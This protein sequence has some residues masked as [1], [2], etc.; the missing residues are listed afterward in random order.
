MT[1]RFKKLIYT[2][3]GGMALFPIATLAYD[4]SFD[5]TAGGIATPLQAYSKLGTKDP[6]YIIFTIV[7]TSL[8]FLGMITI[9]LI[10][11][12]GFMWLF[13]AGEEEKIKKAKD[14]LK[15][16]VT[17]LVIVMASYGLAQYVFTA[18]RYAT[19]GA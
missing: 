19:T 13:A 10:L 3:L 18:I 17:G 2:G 16:A 11:I 7:N 5:P 14:I 1:S 9:V 6:A 4:L 12:A 15:G 8:I